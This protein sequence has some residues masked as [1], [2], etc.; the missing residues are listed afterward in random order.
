MLRIRENNKRRRQL[1]T[2]LDV[3]TIGVS[4]D[5]RSES[6]GILTARQCEREAMLH[7]ILHVDNSGTA[8]QAK[9]SLSSLLDCVLQC[10]DY[11]QKDS[12]YW[13]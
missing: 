1:K 13:A 2:E 8:A 12:L 11:L 9:A 5:I 4:V 6:T 10:D 7:C 3:F